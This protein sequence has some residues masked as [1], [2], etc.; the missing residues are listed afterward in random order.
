MTADQQNLSYNEYLL[1]VDQVN[2]FRN[3]IHLFNQ[4]S[5]SEGAL[6]DLKHKI[7][8]FEQQNPSKISPSSPN[9]SIAGGISAGF[10]KFT[11]YRRMLSLNDI[12]NENELTEWE[13]RYVNYLNK[14][15]NLEK[16]GLGFDNASFDI[17]HVEY[18]CEP[19]IDGLAISLIFQ[20]GILKHGV[21]RGDGYVGEDV[22]AN[23]LN[24]RTI[25]KLIKDNR[26]LEIR[27]EV[28]F[29]NEDF[30][31]LN[32]N[33]KDGKFTGKQG[34]TGSEA[35]FSNPRN[36]ASGTI[37]QLDSQIVSDRNLSFIAYGFEYLD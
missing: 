34:K 16:D 29:T 14:L 18:V 19:K 23:I 6:D 27:G 26:F 15:P 32:Q 5:I 8:L 1:L 35:M 28:F 33:I 20:N 17:S 11:H 24:I 10:E 12:F 25:P 13:T 2:V 36:A 9:L 37:R 7:S 3:E 31:K 22:T 30:K 21:T 4:E